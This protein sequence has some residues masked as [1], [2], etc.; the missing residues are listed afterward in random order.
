MK[1][2]ILFLFLLV[3]F[4]SNAQS[5]KEISVSYEHAD[6]YANDSTIIATMDIHSNFDFFNTGENLIWSCGTERLFNFIHTN[7]C[8]YDIN[9][10]KYVSTKNGIY[11]SRF[12]YFKDDEIEIFLSRDFKELK[13]FLKNTNKSITFY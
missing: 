3:T 2:K 7:S 13:I 12:E 10:M 6:L 11:T 8:G 1:F 4:F 9:R 5:L